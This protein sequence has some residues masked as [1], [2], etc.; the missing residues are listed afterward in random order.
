MRNLLVAQSGGPTS[1]INATLAGVLKRALESD[2]DRI[3]GAKNGIE[4]VL[5]E[6]L[7]DLTERVKEDGLLTR[8]ALTPSSALGSCRYKIKADE[9]AKIIEVFRKHEIA[10]F[11]YIGGN[12][13]MDTVYQLSAYIKEQGIEDIKV[14]GA[15]KTI[16]NDLFG[17]DHCPGF[18]SAAKYIATIFS[19]L[20]RELAVYDLENILIV[21]LMGRNAGWLTAAAALAQ[22]HNKTIP[23]LIYLE[24]VDFSFEKFIEDIK[25]ARKHSKQIMIAVS[26]GIHQ[27][28]GRYISDIGKEQVALDAFGHSQP[29]GVGKILENLVKKEIGCKTRAIEVSLLQ[30]C[31]GHLTS[32]T[33]LDESVQLG[34]HAADMAIK[35]ESGKMSSLRRVSDAPY[36]VEYV[37]TDIALVANKEKKVPGEWINGTKNGVTEEMI[38]YLLPLIQGE[39]SSEFENGLPK[40]VVF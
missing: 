29:G 17:I 6:K 9:F 14:I 37:S 10:Y 21:E 19:E 13:S 2:V 26:E 20:E 38:Q 32:A 39:M 24:E 15:P 11:V 34:Y 25:E 23:Y 30:R 16:D 27:K 28:D 35:G 7:I 3:F 18:A 4:G 36:T 40:Y 5:K 1:A 12:D 22:Y 31:A 33:D 8:L